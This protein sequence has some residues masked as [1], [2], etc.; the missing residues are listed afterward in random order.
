MTGLNK[1]QLEAAA[2]RTQEAAAR[3]WTDLCNYG[4]DDSQ[5]LFDDLSANYERAQAEQDRAYAE[6]KAAQ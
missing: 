2:I 3:A 1:E 5:E 4:D 6:W